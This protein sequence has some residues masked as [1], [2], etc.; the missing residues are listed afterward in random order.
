MMLLPSSLVSSFK[1]DTH[2]AP[3][4]TC[5]VA[6]LYRCARCR[7]WRD[8][9]F[10][11]PFRQRL[12]RNKLR[13]QATSEPCGLLRWSRGA[14][15]VTSCFPVRPRARVSDNDDFLSRLDGTGDSQ[16]RGRG[17]DDRQLL[18]RRGAP[19]RRR[20]RAQHGSR[21]D[22]GGINSRRQS[23]GIEFKIVVTRQQ[24]EIC[25][26]VFDVFVIDPHDHDRQPRPRLT[27]AAHDADLLLG[28]RIAFIH[29]YR[30]WPQSTPNTEK[31]HHCETHTASLP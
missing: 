3:A 31:H 1:N 11:G 29:L 15:G 12:E 21:R 13:S 8:A 16:R 10:E 25:A 9:L 2:I 28:E 30:T 24:G 20:R 17:P 19:R 7:R 14:I 18:L 27:C 26:D 4:A 23:L 22:H 5:E 6:W